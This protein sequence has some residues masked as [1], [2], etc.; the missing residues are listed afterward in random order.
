[1]SSMITVH[2]GQA[3]PKWKHSRMACSACIQLPLDAYG[4]IVSIDTQILQTNQDILV[5]LEDL[6]YGRK[7]DIGTLKRYRGEI[8]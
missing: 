5:H 1:M 6:D 7:S 4:T 8:F 3:D 2:P